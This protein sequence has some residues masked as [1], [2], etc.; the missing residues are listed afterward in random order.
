MQCAAC[1]TAISDYTPEYIK[2][3]TT[4]YGNNKDCQLFLKELKINFQLP[5]DV[6]LKCQSLKWQ[7]ASHSKYNSIL[8]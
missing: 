3:V 8:K 6:C 2:Q 1:K 4:K 7:N 5:H